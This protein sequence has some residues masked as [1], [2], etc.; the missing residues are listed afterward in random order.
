MLRAFFILTIALA[1]A[2]AAIAQQTDVQ[3]WLRSLSH[4]RPAARA[5]AASELAKLGKSAEPAVA[6]LVQASQDSAPE[7]RFAAVDALTRLRL[8]P[9]TSIPAL[10]K[11]LQDREPSVRVQAAAALGQWRSQPEV[12]I[13][14]LIGAL[15]DADANVRARAAQGLQ[16]WDTRKLPDLKSQSAAALTPLLKDPDGLTRAMTAVTLGQLDTEV[17]AAVVVLTALLTHEDWKV[18]QLAVSGLGSLAPRSKSALSAVVE[19]MGDPEPAVRQQAA[20]NVARID[21]VAGLEALLTSVKHRDTLRRE[22]L[23]DALVNLARSSEPAATALVQLLKDRSPEVRYRAALALGRI[24]ASA[25]PAIPDLSGMLEKDQN[26]LVRQV[27]AEAL[28]QIGKDASPALPALL[29]ATSD[30]ND[31]VRDA[32]LAAIKKIAG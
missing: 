22:T 1:G 16:G 30:W 29:Q 11:A 14:A 4:Q 21:P 28:G 18:R 17:D 6:A 8:L 7:V 13:P 25:K 12:A 2:T 26:Y 10:A 5:Q 31:H 15:K 9:E 27:A 23:P 32:A 19:L 20:N 3:P 24:G